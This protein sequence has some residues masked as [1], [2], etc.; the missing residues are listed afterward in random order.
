M[1]SVYAKLAVVAVALA[2]TVAAGYLLYDR[3]KGDALDQIEEQ[4][5]R[6]G[7]AA[8]GG[9]SAWRDCVDADGV[10]DFGTGQCTGASRNGGQ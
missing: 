10:Y 2:V 4:N 8:T 1:R 5:D 3:G 6:A 9:A 7:E